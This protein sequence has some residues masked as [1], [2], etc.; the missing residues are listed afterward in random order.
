MRILKIGDDG[1]RQYT[2]DQLSVITEADEINNTVSKYDYGRD[3]LVRLDNRTE[4]RS[5]FH[6]DILGSTVSLTEDVGST[7]QSI[8]YDAWGNERDRVGTSANNFTFTGHEKDE[9]TGLIYAKSRFYDADIGRFL[10]QD[11]FLGDADNPPSLHLYFYSFSNP[12]RF[13]DLNGFQPRTA[14]EM[15]TQRIDEIHEQTGT[16]KALI[17]LDLAGGLTVVA[18][19]ESGF[20]IVNFFTLGGAGGVR[21]GIAEGDISKDK[22]FFENASGSVG[23]FLSG[24]VDFIVPGAA[25]FRASRE[26]GAGTGEALLE[27]AGGAVAIPEFKTLFDPESTG[28]ERADALGGIAFKFGRL[29]IIGK[30]LSRTR[31]ATVVT[32]GTTQNSGTA[33]GVNLMRPVPEPTLPRP[34][35]VRAGET[36]PPPIV[37]G[38]VGTFGQLKARS[39][40][41]GLEIHE[42]PSRAAQ[43]IA[44]VKS[45]IVENGRPPTPKEIGQ[46]RK[47]NPSIALRPK[48]HAQTDTFRGRNTPTKKTRDAANLDEAAGRGAVDVVKAGKKRGVDFTE[49]VKELHKLHTQRKK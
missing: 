41:S 35:R 27:G 8:F 36:T 10:T 49:E 1:R 39:K 9:E 6:L 3:Q 32:E 2:Y 7:R 40:G 5:F 31:G 20:G 23:S 48:T 26:Q 28:G 16:P 18:G 47:G 17:A 22:G 33:Q 13:V 34:T 25:E 15:L 11:S 19:K 42:S 4:G 44:F 14:N 37:E 12:L 38:D 24:N 43:E 46:F 29:F 21:Q 45:F 30:L